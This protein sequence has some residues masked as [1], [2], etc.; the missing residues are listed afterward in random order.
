MAKSVNRNNSILGYFSGLILL[1]STFTSY[2]QV[3]TPLNRLPIKTFSSDQLVKDFEVFRGS[4]EDFHAGL[5]WYTSKD[6]LDQV[7]D[8]VHSTLNDSL[9]ELEFFRKLTFVTSKIRCGH[10]VIRTSIPTRDHISQAGKLLPF[11]IKIL[12]GKMYMLESRIDEE[13]PLKPGMEILKINEYTTDSLLRLVSNVVSGDGFIE[14]NKIKRFERYFPFFYVSRFGPADEYKIDYLDEQGQKKSAQINARLASQLNPKNSSQK[15]LKLSFPDNNIALLKVRQFQNWKEGK[16]NFR[17]EKELKD[18]FQKISTSEVENLVIDMRDNLG[19]DDNFGLRLFSYLYDQP[20]IEFKE[21]TLITNKS[22]YFKYTKELNRTKAIF[23]HMLFTKKGDDS[24]FYVRHAKTLKPSRP[25]FPQFSGNV[26]ILIN[27]GT[28]STG[29]DFV[30]L[31]KSYQLATFIGEEVGGAYYG[32][33][34]GDLITVKLPHSKLR[35]ILPLIN[36]RTN[37]KPT[38]KIGRGVMP[39]YPKTPAITDLVSGIDTELEFTLELI[40]NK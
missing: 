3:D 39:D 28:Y 37:V 12:N 38:E 40:N 8:D 27:G 10:T 26:Y 32:N 36:Y 14:T 21:Q 7:F 4:L 24:R 16:K 13:L 5:Y 22:K 18:M 30:A 19:G 29:A 34:S 11:E 15:N 6:E 25:S 2:A 1:F 17:F 31:M 33:T 20:I 23:Y 9:S 35:L